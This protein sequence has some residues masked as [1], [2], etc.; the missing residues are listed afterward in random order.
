M[1]YAPL[2]T[3]VQGKRLVRSRADDHDFARIHDGLDTDCERLFGDFVDIIVEEAGIGDDGVVSQRFHSCAT[4]ER[5]A[6]FVEGDVAVWSN[7]TEEKL[8]ATHAR[9]FGFVGCCLGGEVGR[10]AVQDVDVGGENVD[11]REEVFVHEA[12]V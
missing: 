9:D 3:V 8:N 11:M 2:K 1:I 7:T 10:V 6:W 4:C 5:G 12:M